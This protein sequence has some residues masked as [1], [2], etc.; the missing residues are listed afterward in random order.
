MPTGEWKL[1]VFRFL[2]RNFILTFCLWAAVSFVVFL[3]TVSKAIPCS[4]STGEASPLKSIIKLAQNYSYQKTLEHFYKQPRLLVKKELPD[5]TES[6]EFIASNEFDYYRSP[7]LR[8]ETDVLL[9]FGTNSAWDLAIRTN[10]KKLI[11]ADWAVEPLLVTEYLMRP[12]IAISRGPEDFIS[13]LSGTPKVSLPKH[14]SLEERFEFHYEL[15]DDPSLKAERKAFINEVLQR[16]ANVGGFSTY[17]LQFVANYYIQNSAY[18][19]KAKHIQAIDNLLPSDDIRTKVQ[20]RELFSFFERRY[21]GADGS[22][23]V[24]EVESRY[25]DPLFSFLSSQEA[26]DRL[27]KLFQDKLYYAQASFEDPLIFQEIANL[28]NEGN[29]KKISISVSNIPDLIEA[30]K[31]SNSSEK[32]RLESVPSDLETYIQ[33]T[34][35]GLQRS[36]KNLEPVTFY[37]TRNTMPPHSFEAV[38]HNTQNNE[39]KKLY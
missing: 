16:I 9:G 37:Q 11:I 38:E 35:L 25:A 30:V 34:Q 2:F 21:S 24:K 23:A 28:A 4:Q 12:L 33:Q 6:Y 19:A 5:S 36:I 1:F 13:Y 15:L 17:H 39:S 8:K 22:L 7:I 32:I 10:A 26:F 27:K 29:Y 20:T 18:V 31:R 14:L 3:P